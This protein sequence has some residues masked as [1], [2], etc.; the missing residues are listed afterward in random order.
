[1]DEFIKTCSN[2]Y[3]TD[4]YI[5]KLDIAGFFMHINRN[6]LFERLRQF[7]LKNYSAED[8]QLVLEICE[9]MVF[10][11]PAENCIVKGMR[12]DWEDLPNNKSLF[13]SPADCGLPIGNFTS[14]VFANFYLNPFDHF[15][16]TILHIRYY[17][18]Y[19]DDFVIVHQDK[20]FLK[21][22]IPKIRA[23]LKNELHLDLHP[24]KIYLQH[25]SKGVKFL[26]VILKPHRIYIANR[27]KGNFYLA[28]QKHNKIARHHKPTRD[29][30]AAFLNSMNSYLGILKHYKTYKLRKRMI[31]K[32][33]SGWW[34]NY[35]YAKGYSKMVAKRKIIARPR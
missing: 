12:K 15:I 32:H 25:F 18:R 7:I 19:V 8:K 10:N 9:K 14:Q 20:D 35:F 21:S 4:C 28:I 5:L 1:M 2:N 33:L 31:R 34:G 11:N 3:K 27:T 24:K 13:H 17:G 6:I 30:K 29:E 22:L 16:K 23:Y 26:G